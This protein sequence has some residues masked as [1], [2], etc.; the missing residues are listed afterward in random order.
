M[1]I[2]VAKMAVFGC[3]KGCIKGVLRAFKGTVW[4]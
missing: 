1:E 3:I 2:F 4:L